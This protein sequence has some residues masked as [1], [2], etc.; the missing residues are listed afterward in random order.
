MPA[1]AAGT[2]GAPARRATANVARSGT[3][4]QFAA[5]ARLRQA[6]Q[7]GDVIA[8]QREAQAGS[9]VD[10]PDAQGRTALMLAATRGDLPMVRALLALGASRTARDV[11]GQ[12]ALD[13]AQ[14]HGHTA[15]V[16]ALE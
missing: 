13:L 6:A 15:V 4:G 8:V 3:G 1:P 5:D 16:H 7:R 10:A 2:G 9:P 14:A 12:S 11:H